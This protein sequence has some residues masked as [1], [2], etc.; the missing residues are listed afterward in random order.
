M[1]DEHTQAGERLHQWW[2]IGLSTLSRQLTSFGGEVLPPTFWW[3]K[4]ST[5]LLLPPL[6]PPPPRGPNSLV[7]KALPALLLLSTSLARQ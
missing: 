5:L 1:V 2:D 4:A 7:Q 6:L 3:L